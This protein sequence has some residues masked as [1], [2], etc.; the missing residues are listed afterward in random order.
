MGTCHLH[1]WENPE[2]PDGK[3]NGSCHFVWQA[4]ENTGCDLR[5]CNS[6]LFLV[7]S[8]YLEIHCSGS[9][10]Y[11]FMFM[12]KISARVVCV[13]GKHCMF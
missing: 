12:H 7:C 5:G 13:N 9:F 8:A 3:S 6:P 11:S 2:I 4:S 1:A 10:C